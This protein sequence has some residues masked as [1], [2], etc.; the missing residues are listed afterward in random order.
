MM[1]TYQSA[2]KPEDTA[3]QQTNSRQNLEERLVQQTPEWVE[4]FLGVRHVL[5]LLLGV[6]NALSDVTGEVLEH[7][8]EVVFLGRCITGGRLVLGVS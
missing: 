8:G 2:H 3:E 1:I 4:L 7:I 6:L 5:K